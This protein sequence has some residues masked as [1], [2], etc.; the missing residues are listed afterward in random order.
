[1]KHT[2]RIYLKRMF[3]MIESHWQKYLLDEITLDCLEIVGIM[4][5]PRAGKNLKI[6][7]LQD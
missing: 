1:M 3:L 2:Y 7:M 6:S 4:S 5:S